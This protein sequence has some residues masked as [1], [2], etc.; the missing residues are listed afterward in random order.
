M[1]LPF[2]GLMAQTIAQNDEQRFAEILNGSPMT[3]VEQTALSA[4]IQ[5]VS[6]NPQTLTDL[7]GSVGGLM[8]GG[9]PQGGRRR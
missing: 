7:I 9:Q 3:A 2:I 5:Q 6:E 4:L 8:G 1:V